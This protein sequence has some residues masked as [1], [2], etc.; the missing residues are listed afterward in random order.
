MVPGSFVTSRSFVATSV[1]SVHRVHVAVMPCRSWVWSASAG[2]PAHES[3]VRSAIKMLQALPL[4]EAGVVD[5]S[6]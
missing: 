6:A 2:N 1:E 3:F 5:V 4:V